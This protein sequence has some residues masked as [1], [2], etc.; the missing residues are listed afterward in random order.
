MTILNNGNVGIGVTPESWISSYRALQI[1]NSA[2]ITGRTAEDTVTF[3]NN[4]YLDSVNSIWEYIGANG[5]SQASQYLLDNGGKHMFRVSNASGAADAEITWTTA[6]TILNDGNV[7]VGTAAPASLLNLHTTDTGGS[8]SGGILTFSHDD[9]AAS[10][11]GARIG[12]IDFVDVED[13]IGTQV[14]G[15]RISSKTYGAWD[16]NTHG[17][18]LH[19]ATVNSDNT[20]EAP[21]V[22]MTIY[23]GNVT[24]DTGNLV[25]GTAGRGIT[26]S[27]TNDPAQSAGTGG[28]NL[29][30]DYEEGSFTAT[31]TGSTGAPSTACTSNAS[32]TKIGNLVYINIR[33][34]SSINVSGASGSVKITGFPFSTPTSWVASSFSCYNFPMSGDGNTAFEAYADYMVGLESHGGATWSDWGIGANSASRY[35]ALTATYTIP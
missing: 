24:V 34:F 5:S 33:R 12:Q 35:F 11:D 2:S 13:G 31:L 4:A 10:G 21:Q 22:D 3:N 30:D 8:A 20:N 19:F 28:S 29:L 27:S 15:A 7:G 9:G 17:A 1:G 6:M 25:I 16:T 18:K 23:G 32:Y 14:V 26:F